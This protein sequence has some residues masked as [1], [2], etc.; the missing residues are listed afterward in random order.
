MRRHGPRAHQGLKRQ[1]NSTSDLMRNQ[2]TPSNQ[3]VQC[4]LLLSPISRT[5]CNRPNRHY[6]RDK[7]DRFC[8]LFLDIDV[9]DSQAT[10]R[11][12]RDVVN[13]SPKVYQ[14][15]ADPSSRCPIVQ[16]QSVGPYPVVADKNR[17]RQVLFN[18]VKF[19]RAGCI[20]LTMEVLAETPESARFKIAVSD[21][22]IGIEKSDWGRIFR[23]FSQLDSADNREYGPRTGLGLV[24]C[25]T[26]RS[27]SRARPAAARPCVSRRLRAATPKPSNP[28]ARPTSRSASA[29]HRAV[30][31]GRS[32]WSKTMRS[33]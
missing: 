11:R 2:A 4:Q 26:A 19:T 29:R 5:T 33:I 25:K 31:G 6:L 17:L 7:R 27:G 20:R 23:T 22:G 10:T 8:L 3:Q 24:I 16:V 18:A 28:R 9:N 21:T 32:S 13:R 15:P 14:T 1:W 30:A 12:I